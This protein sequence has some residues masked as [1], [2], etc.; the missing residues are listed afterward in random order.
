MAIPDGLSSKELVSVDEDCTE[1][2]EG[3]EG[4]FVLYTH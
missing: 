4:N 2:S 1:D 3:D